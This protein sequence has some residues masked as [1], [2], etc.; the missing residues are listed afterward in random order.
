LNE[1]WIDF[2][3]G[4]SATRKGRVLLKTVLKTLLDRQTTG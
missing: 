4:E 2:E 3:C 1:G